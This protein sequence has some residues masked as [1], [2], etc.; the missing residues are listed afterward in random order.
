V[1]RKNL[2]VVLGLIIT[3][4]DVEDIAALSRLEFS[5]QDKEKYKE[6]LN[7]ILEYIE[8]LNELD[9]EGVMP[10]YH[11]MPMENVMREDIIEPSMDISKVLMNAPL[12]QKGCFKVP[13]IL[14]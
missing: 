5:E 10:T 14:D 1:G 6:Q 12:T 8:Q 13:R 9:T 3:K 2:R 7:V 4:K 11:I